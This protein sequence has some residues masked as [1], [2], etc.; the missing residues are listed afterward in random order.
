MIRHS[1]ISSD[2]LLTFP[3]RAAR[4]RDHLVLCVQLLMKVD[5]AGYSRE[6]VLDEG[7]AVRG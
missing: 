6:V 4:I 2:S 7:F 5:E 1:S 3:E